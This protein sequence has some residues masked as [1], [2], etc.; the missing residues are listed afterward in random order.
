MAGTVWIMKFLFRCDKSVKFHSIHVAFREPP[1]LLCALRTEMVNSE[2]HKLEN[3]RN[4]LEP[5]WFHFTR[6]HSHLT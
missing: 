3:L 5:L 6:D 2:R 1:A 4:W